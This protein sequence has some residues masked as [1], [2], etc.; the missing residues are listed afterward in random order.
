MCVTGERAGYRASFFPGLSR[1]FGSNARLICSCS[2]TA[3]AAHWDSRRPR[4]SQPTPCSPA[5]EPPS[6]TTS[7]N[8]SSPT[9]SAASSSALAGGVDEHGGV[10]VA[11]AAVPPRARAQ[12]VRGGDLLEALEAL[13]RGA[14]SGNTTSSLT[15]AP[16]TAVTRRVGPVAP[17]PQRA[18]VR[19]ARARRARRRRAA[20]AAPRAAR[21]D[22]LARAVDLDDQREARFGRHSTSPPRRS[23]G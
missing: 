5:I 6:S 7:A 17:A 12:A 1:P 10:H 23:P 8:S 9:A 15:F 14:P 13:A 4:L 20:R 18:R 16:R 19:A 21:C 3:R 11:L 2:S 22:L